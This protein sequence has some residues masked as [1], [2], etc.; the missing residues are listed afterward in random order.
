MSPRV[1]SAVTWNT[2]IPR[3][4]LVPSAKILR[5]RNGWQRNGLCSCL[6]QYLVT[7]T[8]PEHSGRS[9]ARTRPSWTTCTFRPPLLPC[10]H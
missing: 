5:Q 2:T 7:L 10:T 6:C 4:G 3:V 9:P 1:Q 8:L